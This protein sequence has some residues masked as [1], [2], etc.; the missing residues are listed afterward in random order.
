M[1]ISRRKL[2]VLGGGAIASSA[3]SMPAIASNKKI[4]VGALRFTSHSAS[5]HSQ[6]AWIF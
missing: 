1:K 3:L 4:K 2:I 6:G 5:F